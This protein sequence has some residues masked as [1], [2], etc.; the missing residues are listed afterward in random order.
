MY[1]V[2]Q[3][4]RISV[5]IMNICLCALSMYSRGSKQMAAILDQKNY[6]EELNRHLKYAVLRL[7]LLFFSFTL[8]VGNYMFLFICVSL[9][10]VN[11]K[12][13]AIHL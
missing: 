2:S 9:Y 12:K 5:I 6:L 10:T 11:H 8:T 4:A 3:A 13:V 1:Y 7:C